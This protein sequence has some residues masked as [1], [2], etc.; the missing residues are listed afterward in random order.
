MLVDACR[1]AGAARLTSVIP[2]LGYARQDRRSAPGEPVGIRVVGDLLAALS[3][4]QAL[5]VDAHARD[6]EAIFGIPVENTTGVP[7]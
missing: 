5:V 6:L 1:R 4:D 7:A 2:Y 3:V